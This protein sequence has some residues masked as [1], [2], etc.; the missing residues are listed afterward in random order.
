MNTKT[1]GWARLTADVEEYGEDGVLDAFCGRIAEGE[2]PVDFCKS[3]GMPWFVMRR[4]LEDKPHRMSMWALAKRCFADGLQ[5]EAIDDVRTADVETVALAKL[6]SEAK[7]RLSGKMNRDEWGEKVQMSVTNVSVD[8]KSLLEKREARLVGSGEV[9]SV[10]PVLED[11]Q[12][13]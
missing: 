7:V 11:R 4:W 1:V 9:V 10:V 13:I 6:Q 3:R 8:I 12:L 2:S 5:Y